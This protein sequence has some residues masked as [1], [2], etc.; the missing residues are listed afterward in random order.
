MLGELDDLLDE[1]DRHSG[2]HDDIP[3]I[4]GTT[5]DRIEVCKRQGQRG[6]NIFLRTN[7]SL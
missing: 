2:A 1:L 5:P 7:E 3:I 4:P 6:K